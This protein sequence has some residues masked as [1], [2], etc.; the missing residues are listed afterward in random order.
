MVRGYIGMAM[1]WQGRLLL[2][3]G[4][5]PGPGDNECSII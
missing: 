5:G 4:A 3:S 1:A 2:V